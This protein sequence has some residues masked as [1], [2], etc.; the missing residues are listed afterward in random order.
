MQ[1]TALDVPRV[2]S[3]ITE[4]HDL[5]R[6]NVFVNW[7]G[8]L[9]APAGVIGDDGCVALPARPTAAKPSPAPSSAAT[10]EN[11]SSHV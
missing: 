1:A 4:F 9:S 11:S 10:A 2:E 7:R 8:K 5:T 3:G 6:A